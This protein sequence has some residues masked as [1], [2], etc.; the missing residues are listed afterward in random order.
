VGTPARRAGRSR[1]LLLG[2]VVGL[3]TAGIALGAWWMLRSGADPGSTASEEVASSPVGIVPAR[4]EAPPLGATE[5]LE[6]TIDLESLEAQLGEPLAYDDDREMADVAAAMLRGIDDDDAVTAATAPGTIAE[7]ASQGQSVAGA[8]PTGARIV[9][10]VETWTRRGNIAVMVVEVQLP[11]GGPEDAF[12][13]W[14]LWEPGD[15]TWR[16]SSTEQMNAA[17]AG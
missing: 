2:A 1:E 6:G 4:G 12:L 11:G 10:D 16:I 9:P 13:V 3:L 15:G 7:L 5:A 14:L 8:L 17:G